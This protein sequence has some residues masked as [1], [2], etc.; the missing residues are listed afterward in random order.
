MIKSKIFSP[1]EFSTF[2]HQLRNI[3][4]LCEYLGGHDCL[5]AVTVDE[6][7]Q[8]AKKFE[9]LYIESARDSIM[10]YTSL[11]NDYHFRLQSFIHSCGFRHLEDLDRKQ[12]DFRPIHDRIELREYNARAPRWYKRKDDAPT[13]DRA[14][15]E[16]NKR[17]RYGQPPDDSNKV[18]NP[19]QDSAMRIPFPARFRDM[20][21]PSVRSKFNPINHADGTVKYNNFHHRG[22]CYSTCSLKSSH[23]KS[24]PKPEKPK[25]HRYVANLSEYN[26]NVHKPFPT[27]PHTG[28]PPTIPKP[29][30]E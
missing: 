28:L 7:V 23:S 5:A 1:N 22:Y 13:P 16:R 6:A 4:F 10:F 19:D 20:F 17:P 26:K 24:I 3:R 21:H 14:R 30:K 12:L 8:H 11:M 2:L 29:G 18:I 25:H 15:Q 9:S 27:I